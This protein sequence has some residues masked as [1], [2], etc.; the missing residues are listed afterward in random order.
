MKKALLLIG[1]LTAQTSFATISNSSYEPRHEKSIETAILKSCGK[2]KD[3]TVIS[4]QKEEVRVDQGILDVYYQTVL[5]A[6]QEID[7]GLF[8]SYLIKVESQYADAYDH[9]S[10]EWGSFMVQSVDCQIQ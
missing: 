4:S 9:S 7:Q 8:D 2:M 6:H 5:T 1:A 3:L 10:Q